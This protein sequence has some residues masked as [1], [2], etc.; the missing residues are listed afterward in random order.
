MCPAK[1]G[2]LAP[3]TIKLQINRL[4][5]LLPAL[6]LENIIELL[7]KQSQSECIPVRFDSFGKI[8]P[9]LFNGACNAAVLSIYG[10]SW[11]RSESL[12]NQAVPRRYPIPTK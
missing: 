8:L 7:R 10:N 12:F 5:L 2:L 11:R 6:D 1:I 3:R 9:E 4:S